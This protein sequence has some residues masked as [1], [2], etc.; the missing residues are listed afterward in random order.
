[1]AIFATLLAKNMNSKMHIIVRA[2]NIGNVKKLYHA[3]ADYVQ[4]LATVSGRMLVSNIFEDETSLAA[5]K[6][7]NLVQLPAGRLSGTTLAKSNV[8]A[9]TGCTILAVIRNG[10]KISALNPKTFEFQDQDEVIIAGT[11]E[12][13][14]NFEE[15]YM[16]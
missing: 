15:K 10:E 9:D 6:R 3:G 7:I 2:N 12:S 1:M 5:E 4:S 8:R 16:D 14:R 13:I 11:D